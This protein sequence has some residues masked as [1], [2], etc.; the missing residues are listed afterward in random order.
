MKT[1][2]GVALGS[3]LAG[4]VLFGFSSGCQVSVGEEVDGTGGKSNQAEDQTGGREDDESTGGRSN[5]ST[6]GAPASTGGAPASTGGAPA[7]TGGTAAAG[8]PDEPEAGATSSGNPDDPPRV[9]DCDS[10]EPETNDTRETAWSL[11]EGA[12]LCVRAQNEDWLYVDTPDDGKAHI[13]EITFAPDPGANV[14]YD[15]EVESDGSTIGGSYTQNG[16][17]ETAWVTLGPKVR[18]LVRVVPFTGSDHVVRVDATMETEADQYSPNQTAE[19]AAEI[20]VNEEITAE[21][22]QPYTDDAN[23]PF[24]DWYSAELSEGA[25]TISFSQVVATQ[26]LDVEIKNPRGEK[27]ASGYSANGGALFDLDFEA[28]MPGTYQFLVTDFIRGPGSFAT[29]NR[30]AWLTQ[31]YRFEIIE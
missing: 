14:D 21:F 29:G 4:L 5:A 17:D 11:L 13:L 3:G 18:A 9:E 25:H 15:I 1:R 16:A 10:G 12:T 23:Q 27:I 24:A 22:H 8:S 2:M 28:S 19:T 31:S 20:P 7:S 30:P 6:G 26:R